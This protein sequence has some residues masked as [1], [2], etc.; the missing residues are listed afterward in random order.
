M[1][2]GDLVFASGQAPVDAHGVTVG[3]GDFEAQAR[4]ALANLDTVLGNAGS[5]LDKAVKLTVFV[6]DM[7]HQEV[8]ARL[9][10]RFYAPPFPAE[11]FVQVAALADPEWLVEIEGVGAV[12]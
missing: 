11:S 2:V 8:F 10:A 9:R 12:E 1:R 3:A 6:T 7:A 4:Q 5:G